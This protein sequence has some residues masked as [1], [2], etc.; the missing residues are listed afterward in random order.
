[1]QF[2]P[3]LSLPLL[4]GYLNSKG[5]SV[6]ILDLN[7]EFYDWCL[8]RETLLAAGP[9]LHERERREA[10]SLSP[11]AW[12]GLCKA[13][14]T[15]DYLAERVEEAKRVMRTPD[16]Y[17]D[18][19]RREQAKVEICGALNAVA[20]A[21]PGTTVTPGE[22]T[23]SDCGL[24]PDKV[25][26]FLSSEANLMNWFY[27]ERARPLI[28][29]QSYDF[30]GFSLPAWEQ[31]IP[32]L[33]MASALKAEFGDGLHLCM[34]GNYTTRLVGTWNNKAHPYTQWVD[35]FS[36]FEGE[37]SLYQL[38]GALDEN[39]PLEKVTNLAF[40]GGSELVQTPVAEVDI[41]TVATPDFDGLV[42][43]RYL[44]PDPIL[45][46]YTSRSCPYKCSFC[47]IPYASSRFRSRKPELVA[48]DMENLNARYGA[49][50]FSF[51]DE[52]LTVPILQT[53]GREIIERDLKVYWYGE[54]RFHP[55][56][57]DALC[58]TL[59]RAGC[60][61][62]QFGLESYNQSVLNAMKKGMKIDII[63][64]NLESCLKNGIAVHLFTFY[65]FPG[66]TEEQARRTHEFAGEIMDRSRD[67]YD[68]PFSTVGS[69]TFNLEVY[70]DVFYKPDHYGVR[71]TD[72][73]PANPF[74]IDY[75]VTRGMTRE[76]SLNLSRELDNVSV[77]H[78]LS[79][80][81]GRIWWRALS[82]MET[83]EDESFLLY[84]LGKNGAPI[85]AGKE[86]VVLQQLL[87][88]QTERG[89]RLKPGVR[90]RRFASDY[91]FNRR[92]P[93]LKPV[94]SF[95]DPARDR[96]VN[97]SEHTGAFLAYC[98][99]TGRLP[100]GL[101]GN[102]TS[103]VNRLLRHDM[104]RV[105]GE[106]VMDSAFQGEDTLLSWNPDVS[107]YEISN[108]RLV[109]F[110]SIA[111][112]GM[113]A[114]PISAWIA[115]VVQERDDTLASLKQRVIGE[116]PEIEASQIEALVKDLLAG[117]ILF[118]TMPAGTLCG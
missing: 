25:I 95:Y 90:F 2:G 71:I 64:P 105:T 62:M 109:L 115:A 93:E 60:R 13:L 7:I 29:S 58:E 34:G 102:L 35:S 32:T 10:T 82:G 117:G 86:T 81:T 103:A 49:K 113:F 94:F 68:N 65:G 20:A 106:G 57:D 110:D 46:L 43:D 78:D 36:L 4:K 48:H 114:N 23:F 12:A 38:L 9:L 5:V 56:I 22:I 63:R 26:P 44:A 85:E 83:N 70:S 79:K 61:K 97:L 84:C 89:I 76:Q 91:V 69:G 92:D 108:G 45:P 55:K 39:T 67:F 50:L 3:Y 59:F 112:T 21:F 66:E 18:D 37:D 19:V 28:G 99:S 41:D 40:A 98:L 80:L 87:P 11:I 111:Q 101:D 74:E 51:V 77:F 118:A 24:H 47:T 42:L 6:S 72:Y 8:S 52:T 14:L 73:D 31:L 16:A 54:T 104:I 17:L 88:V 15:H 1:M 53:L 100:A 75:E 27:R 30:I 107:I 96:C 116:H 33:T